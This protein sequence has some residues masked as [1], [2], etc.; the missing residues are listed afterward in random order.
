MDSF[1]YGTGRF[2]CGII[3]EVGLLKLWTNIGC[4]YGIGADGQWVAETSAVNNMY[5]IGLITLIT[6]AV[7]LFIG[8]RS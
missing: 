2:I 7:L 8:S 3:N 4:T 5:S 6:V 1:I